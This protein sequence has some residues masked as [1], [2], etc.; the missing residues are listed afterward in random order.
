[1]RFILILGCADRYAA[2]SN[3]VNVMM[4]YAPIVMDVTGSAEGRPC[5]RAIS[6][7]A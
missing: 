4:Y 3:R 7:S 5:S 2:T 6:G 1:M